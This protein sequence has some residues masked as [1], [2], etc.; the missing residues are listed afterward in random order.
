MNLLKIFMYLSGRIIQASTFFISVAG[1]NYSC[2][3]RT[4][5]SIQ[6][7]IEFVFHELSS[8]ESFEVFL[9]VCHVIFKV[10]TLALSNFLHFEGMPKFTYSA[11]TVFCCFSVLLNKM[12]CT[13]DSV[14][15]LSRKMYSCREIQSSTPQSIRRC[16]TNNVDKNNRIHRKDGNK[17]EGT[18][19]PLRST[20][21]EQGMALG[22]VHR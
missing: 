13:R 10:V 4:P 16:V 3:K 7:F 9:P 11:L 18:T 22:S 5:S 20:D 17:F 6:Y 12:S 15:L 8:W 1:T 14:F 19:A 21:Y 2:E